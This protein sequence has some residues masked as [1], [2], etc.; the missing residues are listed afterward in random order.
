M[1]SVEE[2]GIRLGKR[3]GRLAACLVS[4]VCLWGAAVDVRAHPISLTSSLINVGEEII[5]VELEIMVEDLLFYHELEHDREFVFPVDGIREKARDHRA[6]LLSYFQLRDGEGYRLEGTVD[7]IDF[8][9][10]DEVAGV[11]FDELMAYSVVYTLEYSL[12]AQPDFLTVTQTFGGT[13][14]VVP[15][16][17]DLSLFH[18][19]VHI[20]SVGGLSHRSAHT[21]ALD[22]DMEFDEAEAGDVESARERRRAREADQLGITSYS[23]VYSYVYIT[24]TEIRHEMLIPLLTL[25]DWVPLERADPDFMSV[26]EQESA[27]PL[28]FEFLDSQQRMKI[29]GNRVEPRLERADFFGPEYRDFA[30]ETPRSEVSVHNARV[31]V[32][33]SFPAPEIPRQMTFEWDHF[34]ERIP[35]LRPRIYAFEEESDDVLITSFDPRYEWETDRERELSGLTEIAPPEAPPRLDLPVLSLVAGSGAL[36]FAGLGLRPRRARR[37]GFLVMAGVLAATSVAVAPYGHA[38]VP[39]PFEERR[40]LSDED[41]LR[42]FQA[43]HENV[44]RAFERRGEEEI[45]EVLR[46]SVAGRLLEDMYLEILAGIR[47]REQGGAVSRVN[48][49]EILDGTKRPVSG[50]PSAFQAFEY[51][52]SWTVTGTV[53]HWGHIHTRTNLYEAVFTV[54]GTADGW[55]FTG[56]EP[57]REERQEMRTRLRN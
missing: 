56:F 51:R 52:C 41:S 10:L 45:Y 44:Y 33:L 21:F 36:V 47:M 17:M 4:G 53:E 20:E 19:G 15:A 42:I 14:P 12:D 29:N 2:F 22:W 13:D 49:I 24:D 11:H 48:E 30:S 50:S 37:G 18:R 34:D 40:A 5:T 43:L 39:H 9:D 32:I 38:T 3:L 16:E 8:S 28:I 27:V 35:L 23:A 6:F 57:I 46:Q 31:G 54:E 55:R 1:G 26:E 25:E 7:E